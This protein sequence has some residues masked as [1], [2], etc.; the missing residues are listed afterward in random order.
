MTDKA[1][2]IVVFKFIKPSSLINLS[3]NSEFHQTK[4]NC[5]FGSFHCS[6]KSKDIIFIYEITHNKSSFLP[7]RPFFSITFHDFWDLFSSVIVGRAFSY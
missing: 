3:D 4:N 1:T 2:L 7:F 6:R 5:Y